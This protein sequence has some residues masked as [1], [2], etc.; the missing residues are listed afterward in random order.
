LWTDGKEIIH[1][2]FFYG[3][4]STVS[5]AMGSSLDLFTTFSICHKLQLMD[6]GLD[7]LVNE[8]RILISKVACQK[9]LG[10]F[11]QNFPRER[12]IGS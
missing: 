7:S 11:Y 4:I 6:E 9:E 2:Y 10:Y 1:M 8:F 3:D 5:L 12:C